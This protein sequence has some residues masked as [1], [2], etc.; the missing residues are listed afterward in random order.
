VSS[1]PNAHNPDPDGAQSPSEYP[2]GFIFGTYSAAK[3]DY[4]KAKSLS[5][6]PNQRYAYLSSAIGGSTSI[7]SFEDTYKMDKVSPRKNHG[8]GIRGKITGFSEASRLRLLRLLASIDYTAFEK[9]YF[10]SLTYPDVWPEESKV[11]K[12][13]LEAFRKRFMGKFGAFP[14]VWRLGAQVRGA[15][16]FHLLLLLP[17]AIG[18]LKELRQYVATSWYEACGKISEGHLL[19]G[20]NVEE[21]RS[22]KRVDYVGRYLAKPE[23]L[24]KGLETGKVWGT[25]NKKLLPIH[26]AT[27]EVSLE[28]AYQIRRVFRRLAKKRGIGPLRKLQVFVRHETMAKLLR[29]LKDD[30]E[31]P[32]GARR[33][34]PRWRPRRQRTSGPRRNEEN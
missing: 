32:K 23:E 12:D 5:N 17:S 30:N 13:Y 8:G 25:W 1:N 34:L 9:V 21:I 3:G 22:L 27:T 7:L 6:N 11:C 29:L 33:P 31:W 14:V 4:P 20:T 10:A 18:S 28:E 19:A 26:W 15:W 24:L 2:I 16:H